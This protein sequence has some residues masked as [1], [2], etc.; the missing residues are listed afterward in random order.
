MFDRINTNLPATQ[1]AVQPASVTVDS[2]NESSFNLALAIAQGADERKA[3][4]IV[5][6]NVE[7]VSY[8]ADYF[9]VMTGFSKVQ[10]RAIAGAIEHK[11][12]ET[13]GRSPIRV[14]GL[15]EGTWA[16]LDYGEV[17]A[18]IFTPEERDFYGLEAFWGHAEKQSFDELVPASS[19]T[20][21]N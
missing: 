9:V 21:Q 15:S 4:N 20:D 14:E 16:L 8:L 18:H 10:V 11:V 6:L 5:L 12:E 19:L 7:E 1:Q 2:S 3:G 17:I 13:L